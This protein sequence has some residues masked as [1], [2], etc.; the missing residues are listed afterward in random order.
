MRRM[1]TPIFSDRKCDQ[2]FPRWSS[3]SLLSI[4][5]FQLSF[6]TQRHR[7]GGRKYALLRFT[8]ALCSPRGYL[9]CPFNWR[10]T[11]AVHPALRRTDSFI[12]YTSKEGFENRVRIFLIQSDRMRRVSRNQTYPTRSSTASLGPAESKN[13]VPRLTYLL[14]ASRSSRQKPGR[15]SFPRMVQRLLRASAK[16]E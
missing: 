4:K 13:D 5:P 3:T 11:G 16:H 9:Y 1:L 2:L 10:A 15:C 8:S 12:E 7:R 6:L 14:M